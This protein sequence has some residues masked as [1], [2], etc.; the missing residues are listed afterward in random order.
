[1]NGMT[2][3]LA[4]LRPLQQPEA[5]GWWPPAPGWWLLALLIV[6]GLGLLVRH[7]WRRHR[8]LAWRR[9]ALLELQR[10]ASTH[11]TQA[12]PAELANLNAL[13]RRA[14]IASA[15][16]ARV[17][18][19]HGDAWLAFLDESLAEPAFRDGTGRPLVDLAYRPR[20]QVDWQ[21]LLE[22]SR[23]WIRSQR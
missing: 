7:L 23:R 22:L 12:G 17:A 11:P 19:L 14:A 15:G 18:S 6:T 4:G 16:R 10:L 21:P 20:G 1:M 3:P 8:R 13:L 5:I 9:R 2:D